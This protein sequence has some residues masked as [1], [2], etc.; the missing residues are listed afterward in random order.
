MIID[1]QIPLLNCKQVKELKDLINQVNVDVLK[2]TTKLTSNI[3][4]LNNN[5]N[6]LYKN[7]NISMILLMFYVRTIMNKIIKG[8][9]TLYEKPLSSCKSII[10]DGKGRHEIIWKS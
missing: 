6:E 4:Q 8:T 2:N 1:R 3:E 7:I 10:I 9:Q 5:V